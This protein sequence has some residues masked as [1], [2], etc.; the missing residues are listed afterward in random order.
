[1]PKKKPSRAA[2]STF[3][4]AKQTRKARSSRPR[5]PKEPV[6][7]V[8]IATTPTELIVT[9]GAPKFEAVTG[10]ALQYAENTTGHVFRHTQ[11]SKLYVLISGR[12]FRSASAQGPWEFVPGGKL[13]EDFYKI[14]DDSPKENVKASIPGT[15]QAL[16]AVIA[17]HVPQT[18]TVSRDAKLN[19]PRFDGDP[20]FKPLEGTS[21]EYVIN[22]ATPIIRVDATTLYAVENG[23]WFKAASLNG[24]WSVADSVPAAIY[25]IPPNAPL[26]YVTVCESLRLHP[27]HG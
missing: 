15:P 1:M 5:S 17:A 19:P 18:A 10:T 9:E 21:L 26:H 4:K 16:E 13:P 27:D 25:T 3:W 24:P 20:Q 14:P 8:F 12:W 11:E 6:P 23:V 7:V 2:R 22:T